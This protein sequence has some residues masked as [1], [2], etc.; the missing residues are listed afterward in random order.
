MYT[1]LYSIQGELPIGKLSIMARPRGGDWLFDEIKALHEAGVDVLVSLLTF[2]EVSEFDLAEEETLCRQHG[3]TCYS[4]PILDYSVPLLSAQTDA[5]IEQLASH[6]SA[7]KHVALHCR[8]GL[9]RSPLIAACILI[10]NG[11]APDEAFTLLSKVRGY[12]VPETAEQKEWAI[13][14]S[15]YSNSLQQ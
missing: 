2:L 11:F 13:A 14:F 1:Q 5:F 6:L 9:G 15:H 12:P 4:F 10:L 7:G 8:Q 3:I